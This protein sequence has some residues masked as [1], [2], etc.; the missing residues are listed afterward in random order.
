MSDLMRVDSNYTVQCPDFVFV[1]RCKD[2][3]IRY[4][5]CP[6]VTRMDGMI[7]FFTEDDDFCSRGKKRE[8]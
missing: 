7:S 5:A 8:E 2:C 4:T 1:V 6:M 3:A